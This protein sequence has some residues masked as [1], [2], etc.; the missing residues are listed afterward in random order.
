MASLAA[1]ATVAS[2]LPAVQV[3]PGPYNVDDTIVFSV[4]DSNPSGMCSDLLKVC[5]G[6]FTVE[7]DPALL[8]L[9]SAVVGPALPATAIFFAGTETLGGALGVFIDVSL[10]PGVYENEDTPTPPTELFSLTFTALAGPTAS[11]RVE[12]LDPG[13]DS[14][15]EQIPPTYNFEPIVSSVS[16]N[17]APEPTSSALVALALGAM[18]FAARRHGR[19][20]ND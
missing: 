8:S 19:R 6:D 10:I 2:A 4:T 16:I 3:S 17:S 18:G 9:V 14:D 7:F 11:I 13:L 5:A 12:P 1:A 20:D 15:G